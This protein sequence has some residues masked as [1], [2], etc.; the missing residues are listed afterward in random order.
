M[1]EQ[2]ARASGLF[3]YLEEG[4]DWLAK[5]KPQRAGA[6]FREV[7]KADHRN[8]EARSGLETAIVR[9]REAGREAEKNRDAGAAL[10]AYQ[11]VVKVH[12]DPD[13]ADLH[14]LGTLL[15]NSLGK[16]AASVA[17]FRRAAKIERLV[18]LRE[19]RGADPRTLVVGF[20]G[21]HGRLGTTRMQ[22]LQLAGLEQYS[23]LVLWDSSFRFFVGGLPG[24][25]KGCSALV[26]LLRA[27]IAELAPE[28]VI[29]VGCSGNG[30]AALLYGH[31]IGADVVH[32]FSPAVSLD[33]ATVQLIQPGAAAHYR[34]MLAEITSSGVDRALLHLPDVLAKDNGKTRYFIHYGKA[35]KDDAE[36]A[37]FISG[38]PG[39]HLI[40]HET[41]EHPTAE[42][43]A[44]ANLLSAVFATDD[45]AKMPRLRAG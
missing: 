4:R 31:A 12:P 2:K 37:R 8:A 32:A 22:F 13:P 17:C 36:R 24:A 39:V 3:A 6:A 20:T 9:L 23:R 44:G 26:K 40:E 34:D 7:L 45:P 42:L 14:R 16:R 41:R 43:L 27:R 38:R 19:K 29:V 28:R 18:P 21:F 33:L 1:T 15:A 30:F 25:A 11:A 10:R 35:A 5:G